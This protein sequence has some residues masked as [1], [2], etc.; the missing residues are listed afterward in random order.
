[1]TVVVCVALLAGCGAAGDA[2][3]SGSAVSH[4]LQAAV[5]ATR[6]APSYVVELTSEEFGVRDP[7]RVHPQRPMQARIVHQAPHSD[8]LFD[9]E[10]TEIVIGEN[11]YL[12]GTPF[13][14]TGKW[15]QLGP[16]PSPVD[17]YVAQGDWALGLLSGAHGARRTGGTFTASATVDR[18]VSYPIPVTGRF[19]ATITA[20]VRSGRV[21]SEQVRLVHAH[22]SQ[23]L[24]LRFSSLG[25]APAVMIPSDTALAPSPCSSPPPSE[26]SN[27]A[28]LCERAAVQGG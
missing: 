23:R 22:V 27:T 24:S 6:A 28:Y 14:P 2:T 26:P 11:E 25:A 1:V 15:L 8:E 18:Y 12:K 7:G 16:F 17:P 21:Q 3:V 4:E 20:V 5:S 13:A 19:S 10:R 9:A